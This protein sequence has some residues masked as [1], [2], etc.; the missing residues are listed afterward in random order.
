MAQQLR[1]ITAVAEGLGLAPSIHM[2]ILVPRDLSSDILTFV[3]SLRQVVHYTLTQDPACAH[4]CLKQNQNTRTK[5]PS[6]CPC[7]QQNP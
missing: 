7:T 1:P 3:G 5:V 4:S 2:G 6:D